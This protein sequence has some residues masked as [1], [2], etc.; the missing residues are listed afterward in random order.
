MYKISH[1]LFSR[2]IFSSDILNL[3]GVR[4]E[5]RIVLT[6]KRQGVISTDTSN[7]IRER[8]FGG[9]KRRIHGIHFQILILI[10]KEVGKC[11]L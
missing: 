7:L 6:A 8:Q 5:N 4:Q 10:E 1:I 3:L 9:N 11:N 2:S